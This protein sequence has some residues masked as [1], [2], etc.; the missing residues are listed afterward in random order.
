LQKV[1]KIDAERRSHDAGLY[2]KNHLCH[3]QFFVQLYDKYVLMKKYK[4]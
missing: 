3:S 2:Y 1:R 4:K